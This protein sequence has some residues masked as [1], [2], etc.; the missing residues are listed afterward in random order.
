[1]QNLDTFYLGLRTSVFISTD[2]PLY[3]V[4]ERIQSVHPPD[5]AATAVV[6]GWV[7]TCN[8][9]AYRNTVS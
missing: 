4:P 3:T 7:H 5:H 6:L 9:T 8:V 2:C 1:M